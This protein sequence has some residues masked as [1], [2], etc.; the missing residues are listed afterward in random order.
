M[1]PSAS[2]KQKVPLWRQ[3]I[4]SNRCIERSRP[5][6]NF[7]V[8]DETSFFLAFTVTVVI[9]S[10]FFEF[11]FIVKLDGFDVS[12]GDDFGGHD[13]V[14]DE[15]KVVDNG[16]VKMKQVLDARFVTPADDTVVH[17]MTAMLHSLGNTLDGQFGALQ[18]EIN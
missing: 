18:P 7:L 11:F 10:D 15:Q 14:V 13:A 4:A 1:L 5:L 12:F 9:L 17:M 2:Q 3:R 6:I 16:A 8:K